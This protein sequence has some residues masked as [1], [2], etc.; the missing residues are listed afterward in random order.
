MEEKEKEE[1]KDLLQI[2]QLRRGGSQEWGQVHPEL[3][4]YRIFKKLEAMF[5]TDPRITA[6]W[7]KRLSA[8]L[9]MG[10]SIQP[11]KT[12]RSEQIAEHIEKQ[13]KSFDF[14]EALKKIAT[15]IAFGFSLSEIVW[16][17]EDGEWRI[18]RIENKV[19]HYFDFEREP[20]GGAKIIWESGYIDRND[21]VAK[22]PYKIIYHKYQKM[23][24]EPWGSGLMIPLYW[25][26]SFKDQGLSSWMKTLERF[27]V[28]SILGVFRDSMDAKQMKA[29]AKIVNE[30]LTKLAYDAV[31]TFA[32][33]DIET[34]EAKGDGEFFDKLQTL[35][36]VAIDLVLVGTTALSGETSGSYSRDE[37]H[38][39]IL[40]Q[41]V[42]PEAAALSQTINKTI[43][44]YITELNFGQVPEEEIPRFEI[45]QDR[46]AKYEEI[47]SAVDRGIPIDLTTFYEVYNVPAP[48]DN[49]AGFIT[50]NSDQGSGEEDEVFA[51]GDYDLF[52]P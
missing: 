39:D 52:M 37:T 45:S 21:I 24:D 31:G 5:K 50:G 28:P 47:M 25:V 22:F 38:S 48:Q 8:M 13:L 26:K 12:K 17:E 46:F 7:E 9:S 44:K 51:G 3:K 1:I 4:H 49:K 19:P 16:K 18:K 33:I 42:K 10:W 32:G 2:T 35:A 40:S 43:I 6:G 30:Q 23:G 20:E 36:N 41:M 15:A 27:A 29:K 14:D 11:G 34:I